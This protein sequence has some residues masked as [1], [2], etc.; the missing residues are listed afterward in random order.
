MSWPNEIKFTL[1]ISCFVVSP[2]TSGGKLAESERSGG[3][4]SLQCATP[5][6]A[7]VSA[8]PITASGTLKVYTA[9]LGGFNRD[10]VFIF[11]FLHSIKPLFD[12]T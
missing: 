10:D 1:Y 8:T 9:K 7:A 6:R 12:A 4:P 11:I 5:T 2:R 3:F